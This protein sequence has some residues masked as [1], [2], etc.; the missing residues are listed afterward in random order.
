MEAVW[1]VQEAQNRFSEVIDRALA[2]GPQVV[3]RHG[4]VVVRV[5]AAGAV[6]DNAAPGAVAADGFLQ[7]LLA[8]PKTQGQA[9]G[10]ELPQ[11]R[12]RKSTVVLGG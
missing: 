11:R 4:K 8:A 6:T 9:D 12:S 3:T 1:Q 7:Y 5:V 10:L 2:E